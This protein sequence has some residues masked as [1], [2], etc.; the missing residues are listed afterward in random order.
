MA[1]HQ[2]VSCLTA[3]HGLVRCMH[4]RSRHALPVPVFAESSAVYP[5]AN[6]FWC[7]RRLHRLD[8]SDYT[9][10]E[11]CSLGL[12]ESVGVFLG[13]YLHECAGKP[14]VDAACALALALTLWRRLQ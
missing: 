9:L 1:R 2:S 8:R 13:D 14:R 6:V 5:I 7:S 12:A 4:G 3:E 11:I 10:E